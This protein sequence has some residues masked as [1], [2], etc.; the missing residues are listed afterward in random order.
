[1]TPLSVALPASATKARWALTVLFELLGLELRDATPGERARLAYGGRDADIQLPTGP[2]EWEWDEPAPI[3]AHAD[4]LPLLRVADEPP[5]LVYST[6]ACLTGPWERSDPADRVGC[7]IAAQGW[8]ARNG[9]LGEPLVHRYAER[10]GQL[11]AVQPPKRKP[12]IVLTHDVDDN[13]RHLFGVRERKERLRR[14]LRERRLSAVRRTAGLI[15]ERGYRGPDPNDRFENWAD[16]HRD[17]TSRPTYFAASFGLFQSGSDRD[18]VAYDIRHTKVRATLRQLVAE[19]A[20]IGLHCSIRA[21]ESGERLRAERVA[22]EEAIGKR[23]RSARHHWWALGRPPEAAWRRQAEAGF[24][25]DCSLGFND[26]VG[27]R[28]G[29]AAPFRPFDPVSGRHSPIRTLPTI[30][31]DA[32]VEHPDELRRLYQTVRKVGGALVLDWHVHSWRSSAS[33][34]AFVDEAVADGARLCTPLELL[35][36]TTR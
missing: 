20:E 13:F 12:A 33:L 30:A 3:V 26:R 24:E 34:R 14:D 31:M 16:S 10:L 22:L 23:I 18:D 29:I 8:L 32:A 27:F 5:D 17:W 21:R 15:K 25:L 9:L 4:G 11:L 1:M 2:S 35:A 6:Y 28:R 7:P 36:E 19:G